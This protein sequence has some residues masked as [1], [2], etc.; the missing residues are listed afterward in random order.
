MPGHRRYS[1]A[2]HH[3]LNRSL[4]FPA[5][6]Y[7]LRAF[8]SHRAPSPLASS[9]S[10]NGTTRKNSPLLPAEAGTLGCPGLASVL[11]LFSNSSMARPYSAEIG[12]Y[13]WSNGGRLLIGQSKRGGRRPDHGGQAVIIAARERGKMRPYT[14]KSPHTAGLAAKLGKLTLA[15]Q[16]SSNDGQLRPAPAGPD[17]T[18]RSWLAQALR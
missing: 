9:F 1:G 7:H 8:A 13:G 15:C 5:G 2:G 4:S 18:W 16:L 6:T 17:R 12:W 11:P 10:A 3:C 14:Q